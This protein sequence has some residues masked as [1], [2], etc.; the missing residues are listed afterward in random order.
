[1]EIDKQLYLQLVNQADNLWQQ[2]YD[3]GYLASLDKLMLALCF[4]L[5]DQLFWQLNDQLNIGY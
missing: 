3:S 2:L 5:E 4:Q 1:M